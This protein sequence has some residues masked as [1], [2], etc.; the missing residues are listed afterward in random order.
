MILHSAIL[1]KEIVY[2]DDNELHLRVGAGEDWDALVAYSV[3]HEWYGMENLSLIPG[4]VG[5][6]AIQNIG[7]YGVEA[8][9][10]IVS[11]EAYEV[12]TG[13]KRIF[14]NLE[15]MYSYRQ[16]IFKQE[17]QRRYIVSHVTYAVRKLSHYHLE[18]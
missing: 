8:K 7:A 17:L 18:Y 16:S 12:A 1:G 14:T 2:E 4:E 5:A 3:T 15:C 6:S 11:V 9:D 10:L 13:A